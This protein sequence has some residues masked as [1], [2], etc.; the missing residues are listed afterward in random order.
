MLIQTHRGRVGNGHGHWSVYPSPPE[1]DVAG[2]GE[3]VGSP[4]QGAPTLGKNSDQ[5]PCPPLG[6]N[7]KYPT[8]R[9]GPTQDIPST[10]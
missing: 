9:A 8:P 1:P 6:Q 10:P 4:C 7:Q 2:G 5:V 3:V